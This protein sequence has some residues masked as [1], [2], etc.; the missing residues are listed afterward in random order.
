MENIILEKDLLIQYKTDL[1]SRELWKSTKDIDISDKK[2][3]KYCMILTSEKIEE[4][5]KILEQG[6]PITTQLEEIRLD[7]E[8]YWY[9]EECDK[10]LLEVL[11]QFKFDNYQNEL[12]EFIGSNV[13]WLHKDRD[14]KIHKEIK[15]G[16]L[17]SEIAE[18]LGCSISSIS[19]INKKVQSSINNLKGRFFEIQY[20]KYLRSLNKFQNSEIVRD[21]APGKPDMYIIDKMKK[22]LYIFSLKNL[23]LNKKVFTIIKDQ[24]K[25]ELEFAY[26]KNSFES[27]NMVEL[28][29]IVFDS[30]TENL[31][32]REVDYKNP[33]NVNLYK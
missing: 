23:E 11:K 6:L 8:N 26:L 20:E 3:E 17:Y 2:S 24:L 4:C 33:S 22:E 10:S 31:H 14:F 9:N 19:K 12:S 18:R 15:D 32:V 29:L 30:L 13:N 25:P 21:G 7:T 27:F 16:T 1:E 5:F 28:Y